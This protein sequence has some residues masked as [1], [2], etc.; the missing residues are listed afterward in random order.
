MKHPEQLQYVIHLIENFQL[1]RKISI[2][3]TSGVYMTG[4]RGPRFKLICLL[5]ALS[6]LICRVAH[7]CKTKSL[8]VEN[9][10]MQ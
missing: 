2:E 9:K 6:R 5:G 4:I 8:V 1:T 10:Q 7:W 3:I